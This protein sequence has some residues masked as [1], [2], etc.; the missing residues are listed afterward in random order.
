VAREY[1]SIRVDGLQQVVRARLAIGLDVDDLK[2]AFSDIAREGAQLASRAAPRLTGTLAA[3]IRGN[4]ARSKA[5]V[6]A[7]RV[8][9][10][11]AGPINYGWAKRG[12]APAGFMQA[13]DREWQPYALRRLV[14]DINSKIAEKGLR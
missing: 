11:Y 12:I 5:V 8:S 6:A 1:A 4:R 14:H 10:P 13:A 3:D 9:V 2:D 7:G